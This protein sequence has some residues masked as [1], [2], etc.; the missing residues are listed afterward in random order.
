MST[1]NSNGSL[2][3]LPPPEFPLLTRLI[4]ESL[5]PREVVIGT[6]RGNQGQPVEITEQRESAITWT[7]HS[8]HPLIPDMKIVRMFYT[9][10]TVDIYSVSKDG[11]NGVRNI[12]PV[13]RVRIIE[14]IMPIE[15][16]VEELTAAEADHVGG[17][18]DDGDD[19]DSEDGDSDPE[20]SRDTDPPPALSVV[21]ND[22]TVS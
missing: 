12:I 20:E 10:E 3:R 14:E 9:E 19:S 7:L 1:S 2:I 6:R 22:P 8:D 15:L 16:F 17:S 21:S 5:L 4:S 18:E 13:N 11:K